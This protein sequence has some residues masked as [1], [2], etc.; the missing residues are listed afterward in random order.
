MSNMRKIYPKVPDWLQQSSMF[1]MHCIRDS[2]N[3]FK[4]ICFGSVKYVDYAA[5]YALVAYWA[6]RN[7]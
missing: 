1:C 3:L 6:S 4:I 5:D 2:V 7:K